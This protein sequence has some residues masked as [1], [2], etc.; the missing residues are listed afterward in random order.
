MDDNAG[1]VVEAGLAGPGIPET[2]AGNVLSNDTDPN[3]LDVLRVGGAKSGTGAPP[4]NVSGSA[5]TAVTGKYGT[6]FI[7]ADG[8]YRYLLDNDDVDTMKLKTG[9]HVT[10]VFTYIMYDNA[11][12]WD[13]GTIT[14]GIDGADDP[15]TPPTNTTA[16]DWDWNELDGPF[17]VFES[18]FMSGFADFD[19][20]GFGGNPHHQAARRRRADL[21]RRAD[22]G[23]S[24]AVRDSGQPDRRRRRE[25]GPVV[26]P[27]EPLVRLRRGVRVSIAGL[28]RRLVGRL[29][30][31]TRI[32]VDARNQAPAG[33]NG[34]IRVNGDSYTFAAADF[35]FTDAGG[36]CLRGPDRQG[37]AGPGHAL[38]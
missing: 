11:G 36:R 32:Q 19:G 29:R 34:T 35:G 12:R 20:D 21:Q 25:P 28:A 26:H 10:E 15:N 27:G 17:G 38:L 1:T 6:L 30:T 9:D 14:V 8:A 18:D 22:H 31:A 33:T 37:A 2:P 3:R 5:E 24:L 16:N 23:A 13:N 7:K 4:A